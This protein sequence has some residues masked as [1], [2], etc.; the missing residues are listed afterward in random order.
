[1]HNIISVHFGELWLK[2]KNRYQFINRLAQNIK[3]STDKSNYK[4]FDIL[5]DRFIIYPTN[6]ISSQRIMNNLK[7]I[8]GI[9]WYGN[10]DI[11]KND[12][13]DIV[14]FIEKI[15][16]EKNFR[17]KSVRI[18][19]HRSYKKLPFSSDKIISEILKRKNKIQ[20]T[21]EKKSDIRIIINPTKL[22]TFVYT[23]KIQGMGGL[24]IGSSG[25][26]VIL[27]SGGIDSPV[28]AFYAMKRGL[29]PIYLHFHAFTSNTSPK[30][31]KIV[32]LIRILN[33]YS[34]N[35]VSYMVPSHIFESSII[36]TNSRYEMLLF[37]RFIFGVADSIATK[38]GASAIITGESIG[39]VASQT[40]SNLYTASYNLKH[41]VVRPLIGFDKQDIIKK[42]REINT[43]ETSIIKYKD[44]C[45][46]HASNPA[47]SSNVKYINLLYKKMN[48]GDAIEQ[49]LLRGGRY[50]NK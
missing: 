12:I 39:Q 43:Y 46:F 44:I 20:C 32:K 42:A 17:G 5:R 1:M 23:N 36:E 22:G 7:Y 27:F 10:V 49:T 38:E 8:F 16:K 30:I 6:N 47:T 15:S 50:L 26:A 13:G 3:S 37:K 31:S 41:L 19:A 14:D 11:I 35:S 21:L 18:D 24:P 33:K 40:I 29:E 2:G 45:S 4:K 34:T 25:K 48:I 9:S 28:A